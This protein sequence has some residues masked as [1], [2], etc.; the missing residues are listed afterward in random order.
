M[1]VAHMICKVLYLVLKTDKIF[2][3]FVF[4][5]IWEELI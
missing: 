1:I 2:I 5:K 3:M 4:L